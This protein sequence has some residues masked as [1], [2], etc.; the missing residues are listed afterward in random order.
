MMDVAVK[1]PRVVACCDVGGTKVLAGLVDEQ[2]RI[3]ARERYLLGVERSPEAIVRDLTVCFQ[4]LARNA[5]RRW[6]TVCGVGCS[7]T[8]I[9]DREREVILT[10]P[11]LWP[12]R[13]V[14]FRALLQEACDRPT[15]VEM[16]ACAAALGEAWTGAAA[17]AK[18][19]VYVVVGTGIGAGIVVDGRLLQGSC[20]TAGELGHIT[21]MPDGPACY[22]GNSGCLEMLA[23]GPSIAARARAALSTGRVTSLRAVD[24]QALSAEHVFAAARAGDPISL[25]V[26]MTTAEYLGIGV[27]T[28]AGLFNPQVIALG[29]GVGYGGADLM[30]EPIRAT[31][32]RRCPNWIDVAELQ[33]VTGCL[34]EDAGLIG[35]ARI[36]WEG[37]GSA[38]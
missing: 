34:G 3:L 18:H 28:A 4:R 25:E 2:G 5:G 16:D 7:I 37:L 27:A 36:A 12:V 38:D 11:N 33:I 21:I 13:N 6:A 15:M 22:C 9:F 19:F 8:G 24:V 35:A 14:P 20:G 29:G 32:A 31:V 26:V 30:L 23:S 10:S 1:A 17:S